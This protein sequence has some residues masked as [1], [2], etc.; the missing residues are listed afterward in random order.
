MTASAHSDFD[1][2]EDWSLTD[3]PFI[4]GRKMPRLITTIGKERIKRI[5]LTVELAEYLLECNVQNRLV[6]QKSL[7][8]LCHSITAGHYTISW[9]MIAISADGK[10]RNGQHR[11]MAVIKTGIPV[12]IYLMLDAPEIIQQTGDRGSARSL[13]DTLHMRG[14]TDSV[15]LQAA[16]FFCMHYMDGTLPSST[17]Y[18]TLDALLNDISR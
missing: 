8:R 10:L 6:K 15:N 9:D 18:T 2:F 5:L 16:I 14:E 17:S 7:D 11:C 3:L 13:A 12:E 4:P 1:P